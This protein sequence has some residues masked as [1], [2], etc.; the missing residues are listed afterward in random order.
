MAPRPNVLVLMCDQMQASRMG[1]VDSVAHTPFLDRLAGEGVH[2]T[3]AFTCH[4]QCVP[5]R[6][7]FQ[8]GLYPHECG[9]MAIYGFHGHQARLTAKYQTLGHVFQEAGYQTAYFGKAHFGV[10]LAD[11]GYQVDGG[12]YSMDDGEARQ[13]GLAHVPPALR[14]NYRACDQACD[15]L[16]NW[17]PDQRPLFM[18]FST[19]LPHP[20]FFTEPAYADRFDPEHLELPPSFYA[21]TFAAKPPFQ[22]AH[23]HDGRHG[24]LDE[25]Q[26]RGEL[27]QYYT[28]IAAMDDHFSRI[29]QHFRRLGL[30]DNTLVLFCADHGDMMGAHK[31]RLKG[32]LPYDE[33]YRI[34]CIVK[35]PAAVRP[36]RRTVDDL[37][38]SVQFPGT[39]IQ[40]A[41]LERPAQFKNGS[42][43]DLLFDDSRPAAEGIFYEHYAAYWGIHPFYAR[44]TRTHKYVRYYGLDDA[45]EELY[46]LA[47][48]PDELHNQAANPAYAAVRAE[49]SGQ[50]DAWWQA[51]NGRDLAY[52]EAADFKANRHNLPDR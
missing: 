44:R 35:P 9:V 43:Y 40:G 5:A 27:A 38:C 19:N 41:G 51:T 36:A 25:N 3:H 2:F 21:E 8:T 23:A 52:Y 34:P 47:A 22:Q 31:M 4:G 20:P 17:D 33:L 18:T 46:H 24:A 28:M 48:D 45:C 50:A 29:A 16:H 32:T 12:N 26:L 14:P 39:L 37:V 15:F 7:S 42:A 6:A 10:P 30:W 1:F 13:L 49:L 11:L